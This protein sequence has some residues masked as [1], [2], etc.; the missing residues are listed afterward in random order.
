MKI[1]NLELRNRIFLAPMVGINDIAFRMLCKKAGA[2]LTYTGM[3]NPLS[4]QELELDDF[5]AIQ[6]FSK[7]EMGIKQFIRKH[8]KKAALFDFNLGCPSDTAR[9]H[10][11]GYFLQD[12]KTI[13]KILRIMRESTDKPITIKLRISGKTEKMV[14]IAEKYC[15]AIAIHPRTQKQ[16]YSGTPDLKYAEKIK[17]LIKLPVIYS[18]NVNEENCQEL[19]EKFD[20]VMIGRAAMGDPGIF[21]RL[22]GKNEEF[23]FSDYLNLAKKY[24]L[25]FQQIKLQAMNFTKGNLQAKEMRR[26]LISAKNLEDIKKI[27]SIK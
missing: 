23:G 25:S 5:P 7:S 26:N 8:E 15:D 20:F 17:K 4:K 3:V 19:L 21:A 6:L 14:E 18:G 24:K 13:E 10:G 9:N 1:G 27:Y 12:L 11:V 2:G 16:G 22:N